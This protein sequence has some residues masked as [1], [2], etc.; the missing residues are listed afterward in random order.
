MFDPTKINFR[1]PEKEREARLR[2]LLRK[3][4]YIVDGVDVRY[5]GDPRVPVVTSIDK[6]GKCVN[7]FAAG[8]VKSGEAVA[9]SDRTMLEYARALQTRK[10]YRDRGVD[11][12]VIIEWR[13]L[14][15]KDPDDVTI[16]W[17][18]KRNSFPQP[19]SVDDD[20]DDLEF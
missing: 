13:F 10:Q 16:K 6:D 2:E 9:L 14:N 3:C 20:D 4:N 18:I 19:T 15:R 12:E 8:N 17:S 5:I 11:A 7:H 1:N